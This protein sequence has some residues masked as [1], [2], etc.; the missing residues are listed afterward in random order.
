[1]E[2]SL[3]SILA[4]VDPEAIVESG[5]QMV[6]SAFPPGKEMSE[7]EFKKARHQQRLGEH[8]MYVGE[9]I[10]SWDQQ[11]AAINFCTGKL[12]DPPPGYT[13]HVLGPTYKYVIRTSHDPELFD[14][15]IYG[16]ATLYL[17]GQFFDVSVEDR[18]KL[19]T[20][21][22][23]AIADVLMEQVHNDKVYEQ[24]T[25]LIRE[26]WMKRRERRAC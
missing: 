14:C 13:E 11:L 4:S 22:T 19:P 2:F 8:M 3:E 20:E 24:W 17:K 26:P 21:Q 12:D 16:L 18:Y 1:M 5:N 9:N 23:V 25:R 7:E 10:Q 15:A 6:S